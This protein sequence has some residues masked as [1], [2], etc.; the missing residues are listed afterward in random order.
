MKHIG[1]WGPSS[2]GKTVWLAQLYLRLHHLKTEWKVFPATSET[3]R[4]IELMRSLIVDQRRFPDGTLEGS[5]V[6]IEYE[7]AHPG[8]PDKLHVFT[9]DR[10]GVLSERLGDAE[11][12]A[13]GEAH[14]LMV[15]LDLERP[16]YAS[17]VRRTLE[18]FFLHAR[19]SKQDRDMRPV[20]FCLSKADRRISDHSDFE[21][22]HREPEEFVRRQ[23]EPE[24]LE[25]VNQ[26][27]GRHTYFPVSAVGV[28]IDFGLVRPAVYYDERLS[29]RLLNEGVPVHLLTPFEWLFEELR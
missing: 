7:F 9:E 16:N 14:G 1:L 26:Y 25:F 15:L 10:A 12:Q 5:G 23:L 28:Q 19:D 21:F 29:L 27:C 20:V 2:S 6:K 24:L 8:H 18:R 3:Q 4:F 22:A 13:F 11:L 17:E